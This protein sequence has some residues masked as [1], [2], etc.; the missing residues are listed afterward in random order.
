MTG[1]F[2]LRPVA[3]QWVMLATVPMTAQQ[4]TAVRARRATGGC[5]RMLAVVMWTARMARVAMGE[6]V[7]PFASTIRIVRTGKRARKRIPFVSTDLVSPQ[8]VS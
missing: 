1:L 2:I 7:L 3:F 5:V 8:M 6:P 4:G